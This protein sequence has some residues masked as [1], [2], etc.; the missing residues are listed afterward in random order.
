M[1]MSDKQKWIALS[2]EE[3]RELLKQI[4]SSA[5]L[6]NMEAA[7]KWD[8]LL[9]S[10]QKKL[11]AIWN[12][13]SAEAMSEQRLRELVAKIENAGCD[14]HRGIGYICKIHAPIRELEA[15]LNREIESLSVQKRKAAQRGEPALT[16]E[17]LCKCGHILAAHSVV[18]NSYCLMGGCSCKEYR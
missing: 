9:P 17:R 16:D 11:S 18:H 6:A 3:R 1:T 5:K 15:E 14:C 7:Y 13:E 10:T 4:W 12:Q 2:F 8:R